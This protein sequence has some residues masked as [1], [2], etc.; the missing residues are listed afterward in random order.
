[1]L[2]FVRMETATGAK[3]RPGARARRRATRRHATPATTPEVREPITLGG[4]ARRHLLPLGVYLALAIVVTYPL[5]LQFGT[6]IPGDGR[7]GWQNYWDYWWLRTALASGQNPYRM[8]LIYAPYGAPLYLHTLNLFN[9][10][11]SLP[12]QLAFGLTAAYNAVVLISLTLAAYFAMNLVGYVSNSRR[13]GFIG[14][15]IYAF[16]SY[17]LTQLL[18]HMNLLASEWLPAYILCLLVAAEA[19]GR[20]R[21]TAISLGIVALILLALCDWQ[22]VLFA[23]VF[24]ILYVGWA[25]VARRSLGPPLAA[26]AI[27]AGWLVLALPL[28]LPTVRAVRAT[29]GKLGAALGPER[30]SADLLSFVVPSPLHPWWGAAAE[31]IGVLAVALPAERAIF[32]GYLPLLLGA[33]GCWFGRR[34]AAFWALVAL[35]AALLALGPTLQIAGR[36][37]AGVPLPYQLLQLIPGVNISRGPARFAILTTLCL[38]VLAGL[39]LSEVARRVSPARRPRL[40]AL[41]TPLL[42]AAL[43]AEH[44]AVPYPLSAVVPSPFYQQLAAAREAGSVLEIPLVMTRATSLYG[45][46]VHGRPIVGGYLSRGLPYPVLELPPFGD[47]S[48]ESGEDIVPPPDADVGAWSLR[49]ADVRWIVVLLDDPKLNRE[50]AAAFVARYAEP[51]PLYQDDRM[52]AYRPRPTGPPT[53]YTYV[54]T[55]WHQ[56]ERLPDRRTMRWLPGE[57]SL[58]AW[59][60][61]DAPQAGILRFEAWSFN[62]PRRLALRVDGQTVGE[63]LVAEPKEYRVPLTL[64]PGQHRITLHSLDPPERPS[65]TVGGTD[66]RL[67]AI[68][69]TGLTL[70]PATAGAAR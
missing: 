23:A 2:S 46:T 54:G 51:T 30:F 28:L 69:V 17:H 5:V 67:I 62:Q 32:L 18:G 15:V 61:A 27:G 44:L 1:M 13:A 9:G 52:A 22:Y 33:L 45:Q 42:I 24:T 11:L 19:T 58:D 36:P 64:T 38:A 39:A 53:F 57:G 56:Q 21:L 29:A 70:R 66:T 14:G 31:R 55:G 4:V 48:G 3:R 59:S 34:K 26:A 8:P 12:F 60:L 20:R 43:L 16:G 49:L 25:T 40:A 37:Y 65:R 7:D 10:L 63:W 68:G 47:P 6:H 50:E 35:A 41:A